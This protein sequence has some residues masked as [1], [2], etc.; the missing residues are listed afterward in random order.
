MHALEARAAE[1]GRSVPDLV[2]EALRALLAG[3]ARKPELP[4]L[5]VF[6]L[7]GLSAYVDDRDA[8]DAYLAR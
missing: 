8:L 3:V 7:G 2:N 5:P 6:D 4:P 1:E